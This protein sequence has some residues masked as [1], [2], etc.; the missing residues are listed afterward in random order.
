MARPLLGD[1]FQPFEERHAR[2]RDEGWSLASSRNG[3]VER[4]PGWPWMRST[5][6]AVGTPKRPA[7]SLNPLFASSND[8]RA[9]RVQ[10]GGPRGWER[11]R[12]HLLWR[13]QMASPP[14]G[15]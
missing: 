10:H 3:R 9:R 15:P 1:L 13:C 8:R 5:A 2:L 7:K 11:Q 14:T 4:P 6:I 12:L